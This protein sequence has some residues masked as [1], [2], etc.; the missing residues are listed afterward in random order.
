MSELELAHPER[1]HLLWLA[2][3]APPALFA[4]SAGAPIG[5]SGVPSTN[6]ID[7]SVREAQTCLDRI[8]ALGPVGLS[9][10]DP[11]GIPRVH[12]LQEDGRPHIN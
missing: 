4:T 5:H 2:V 7:N 9:A 1:V 12:L 8:V 10:F 3:L 11:A 6:P